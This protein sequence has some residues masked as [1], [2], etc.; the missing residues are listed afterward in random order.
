MMTCPVVQLRTNAFARVAALL[1]PLAIALPAPRAAAAAEKVEVIAGAGPSTRVVKE[2]VKVLAADP[3][4]KGYSF[5]VPDDS[6]KHQGG[7]ENA[8]SYLFGR[9]GRPLNEQEKAAGY[10]EILLAKMPIVFVAGAKAGVRTLTAEDVCRIYTGAVTSWKEVGGSDER[11]VLITREPTEALLQQLKQDLPCM[12]RAVETRYVLKNDDH[13]VEMLKTMEM[14][15]AAI[16]FGAAANFPEAIRL[17][18]EGVDSGT[19]LGIVYRAAN[20]SHPVVQAAIEAA[21]SERWLESLKGMS[22]AK[23]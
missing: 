2:F 13:L 22:F 19:R 20:R 8:A 23:P 14:G 4:A 7:I 5:R 17:R 21:G 1:L 12:T 15:R 9:T 3:R 18:V 10:A 6:V 11:I 16:G